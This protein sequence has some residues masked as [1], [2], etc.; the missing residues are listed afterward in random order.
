[1]QV[2]KGTV[3]EGK[4]VLSHGSLPEGAEV[5]VF[6][7]QQEGSVRLSPLLRKELENALE[8]ADREDGI[9]AEELFAELRK[10]G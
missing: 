6:V 2:V 8:E 5:G 7:A 3:V 10:Y 4:I 1:M 9:S